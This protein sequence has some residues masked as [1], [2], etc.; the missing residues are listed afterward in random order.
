MKTM[1]IRRRLVAGVVMAL[2]AATAGCSQAPDRLDAVP[3][4]VK[5]PVVPPRV[6]HDPPATFRPTG[7]LMPWEAYSGLLNIAG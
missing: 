5:Q 7:V 3:P 2:T 1:R 4:A 6:A